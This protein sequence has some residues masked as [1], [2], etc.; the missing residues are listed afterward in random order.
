MASND[1]GAAPAPPA[2]AAAAPTGTSTRPEPTLSRTQQRVLL[3]RDQA[4]ID[5]AAGLSDGSTG[6]DSLTSSLYGRDLHRFSLHLTK[7]LERVQREYASVRRM[8]DPV[9]DS[10]RRVQQQQQ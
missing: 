9:G 3:Q 6:V 10:W 8:E 4:D 7:E 5:A 2:A 1:D